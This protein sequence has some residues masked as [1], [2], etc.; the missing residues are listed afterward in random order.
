MRASELLKRQH[1]HF[2]E[3]FA[4]LLTRRDT[5]RRKTL[6]VEIA[7]EL[8]AHTSIEENVFYPA[9]KKIGT[10]KAEDM[11]LEAYEEHHVVKIVLAELPWVD[12]E[13]DSFG[14]KMTVLKDLIGHHCDEEE[15][16]MFPMAEKR[17]GA[18]R[19]QQLAEEIA[20]QANGW[21][22][23]LRRRRGNLAAKIVLA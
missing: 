20:A 10:K 19:S 22:R 16:E 5:R 21:D 9:V 4:Q 13:A 12:P 3:L 1:R 18:S 7:N 14:A 15:R 17:L 11:V 6:M 23:P 2:E 8:E